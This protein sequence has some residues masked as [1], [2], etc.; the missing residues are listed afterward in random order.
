MPWAPPLIR[1]FLHQHP[2]HPQPPRSHPRQQQ[3]QLQALHN[4]LTA[5][6]PKPD[7][8]IYASTIHA[9]TPQPTP[10]PKQKPIDTTTPNSPN[11]EPTAEPTGN[12]E[13]QQAMSLSTTF[14]IAGGVVGY[15]AVLGSVGLISYNR[16]KVYATKHTKER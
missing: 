4:Q 9:E 8:L 1:R 12:V 11:G 2:T 13:Q 16:R 10:E 3:P 14:L 5:I 7:C 15:A 6:Q